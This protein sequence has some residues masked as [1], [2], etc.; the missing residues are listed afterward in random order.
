MVPA[1]MMC[2]L[3]VLL[4]PLLAGNAPLDRP[5]SIP[6]T[7]DL[8]QYDDGTAVWL[9][10]SGLYREVWFHVQDLS[11]WYMEGTCV[12]SLE[13]WFYHHINYPWDTASF[14]AEL[15]QNCDEI[16]PLTQLDQTSVMAS[17]N[18]PCFVNYS[19]PVNVDLDF[20]VVINTE[21]SQGGWPSI[22]GDNS[23]NPYNHSFHTDDF[24]VWTPW[25]IQGPTANDYIVRIYAWVVN[26]E[27]NTWGSIKTLF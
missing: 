22:L 6:G 9:S 10:W 12:N 26:L 8:F 14:Y 25:I 15:W 5:L 4:L 16:Y 17:H 13:F 20:G 27:Q 24:I 23:P 21:M 2:A 11:P 1:L 19:S 3:Q 18:A 7:D